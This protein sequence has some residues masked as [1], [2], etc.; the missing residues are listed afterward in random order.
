MLLALVPSLAAAP[1]TCDGTVPLDELVDQ[2]RQG[3]GAQEIEIYDG[4]ETDGIEYLDFGSGEGDV[5]DFTLS[6]D[7]AIGAII[8]IG[9][10]HV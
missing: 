3:S 6:A 9:R 1:L 4:C 5:T 7:P 10:A 8:Q 2:A